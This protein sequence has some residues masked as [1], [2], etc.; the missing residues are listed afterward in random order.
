MVVCFE[1]LAALACVDAPKAL[2]T[3]RLVSGTVAVEAAAAFEGLAA[4]EQAVRA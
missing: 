1:P 4:V 3:E 2:G